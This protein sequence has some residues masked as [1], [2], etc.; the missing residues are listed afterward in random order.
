MFDE[1]E[2]EDNEG[3]SDARF[4]SELKRFEEMMMEVA[5]KDEAQFELKNFFDSLNRIGN[6]PVSLGRWEMTG[7]PSQLNEIRAN[8]KPL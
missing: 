8:Y 6:I 7:D 2:N 4:N 5:K 1:E 3:M